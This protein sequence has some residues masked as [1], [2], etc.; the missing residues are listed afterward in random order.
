MSKYALHLE[1]DSKLYC[2][3][4]YINNKKKT[5]GKSIYVITVSKFV[6]FQITVSDNSFDT[7]TIVDYKFVSKL[8]NKYPYMLEIK[9]S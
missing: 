2:K 7:N 5:Y 1:Y 4:K 6:K 9:S 3:Y 8:T